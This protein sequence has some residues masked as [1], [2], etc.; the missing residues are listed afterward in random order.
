[1][2]CLD[3]IGA[4]SFAG[5]GNCVHPA[6]REVLQRGG[7]AGAGLGMEPVPL[8]GDTGDGPPSTLQPLTPASRGQEQAGQ[9]DKRAEVRLGVSGD[10][11]PEPCLKVTSS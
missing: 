2:V 4:C 1:M 9:K 10:R 7:D 6:L 5:A 3:G 8:Q 11:L